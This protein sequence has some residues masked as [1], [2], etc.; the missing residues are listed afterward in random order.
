MTPSS[1][2][3]AQAQPVGVVVV[4]EA[5]RRAAP[6]ST[7]F[8]VEIAVAAQSAAQALRDQ[9]SKTAHIAQAVA[10]L[11]VQRSDFHTISQNVVNTYPSVVQPLSSQGLP[12]YVAPP[13]IGSGMGPFTGAAAALQPEVQFGT[14]Q[15]RTVVR[16]NVQEAARAGEAADALTK[17][18]AVLVG[19]FSFHPADE[20]A[21]RKAALEAAGRDARAK[22]EVLAAAAGKQIGDPVAVLEDVV[23]S[24]GAYA[25]LRAQSP[26]AF[27][28]IVPAPLGELEYYARVTAS[29]RFQ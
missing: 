9:Q 6:E 25:A 3:R 18:G 19:G 13:Q 23:I 22:A 17:A 16:V 27:G 15:A 20:G 11:G 29:F 14:Y 10:H 8:L 5:I 21:A 4:G 12:P 7:E 1:S 24:N 28:G 26:I 2:L